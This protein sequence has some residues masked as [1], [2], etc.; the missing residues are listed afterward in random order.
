MSAVDLLFP[1]TYRR[2]VLGLMLLHPDRALHVREIARLTGTTA[3]TLNKE[4]ARLHEAQLL[5]REVVGNQLRYVANRSNP[6]YPELASILKKTIGIGDV[7]T[8]ALAPHSDHISVALIFGSIARHE[9][10]SGSDI[11]LLVI[12]DISFG[13][14]VNATHSVQ[15]ELGRE[16]NP[17]VFSKTEWKQRVKARDTFV[18]DVLQRAKIYLIGNDNELEKLG[19]RQS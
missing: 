17:Q 2:R 9:E 15:A 18:N 1:G 14:I 10:T 4:L 13:E 11:D 7:L 8:D 16:V 19:R 12:G 6:L 3:G 5:D